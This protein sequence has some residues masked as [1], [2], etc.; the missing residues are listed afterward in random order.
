ML[1]YQAFLSESCEFC[2]INILETLIKEKILCFIEVYKL[3][4]RLN[5]Q[6]NEKMDGKQNKLYCAKQTKNGFEIICNRKINVQHIQ[7]RR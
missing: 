1:L 7:V 3:L 2:T 5:E 6:R 4:D